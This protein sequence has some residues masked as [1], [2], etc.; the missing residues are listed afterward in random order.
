MNGDWQQLTRRIFLADSG[1]TVTL[2]FP[3]GSPNRH[4]VAW[5]HI[6]DSAAAINVDA[7]PRFANINEGSAVNITAAGLT[8]VFQV[9]VDEIRPQSRNLS[10][11]VDDDAPAFEPVFDLVVTNNGAASVIASI[12]IIAALSVGGS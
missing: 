12:Y 1:G 5:V 2:P 4:L 6:G 11:H 7:Q 10:S 3:L 8:K 9:G